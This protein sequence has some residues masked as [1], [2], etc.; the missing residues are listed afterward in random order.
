MLQEN[1]NCEHT[2]VKVPV[3]NGNLTESKKRNEVLICWG[4]KSLL[5]KRLFTIPNL[6]RLFRNRSNKL[7]GGIFVIFVK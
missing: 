1:K 3:F 6:R 2:G 4:R 5:K 7:N